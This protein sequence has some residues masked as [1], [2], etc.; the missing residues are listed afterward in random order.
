VKWCRHSRRLEVCLMSVWN[1][2]EHFVWSWLNCNCLKC[3]IV[4]S[5]LAAFQWGCCY[6]LKLLLKFR[7]RLLNSQHSHR[8]FINE[9]LAVLLFRTMKKYRGCQTWLFTHIFKIKTQW[10]LAP[11]IVVNQFVL[12]LISDTINTWCTKLEAILINGVKNG[13]SFLC[14]ASL[15]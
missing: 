7:F 9:L 10:F 14:P 12:G 2:K 13:T 8:I 15:V 5:F 1:L 4:V 3:R 6:N 11:I